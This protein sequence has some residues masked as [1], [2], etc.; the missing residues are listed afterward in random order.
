MKP[1]EHK[2]VLTR[3]LA[4]A[5]EVGWTFVSCDEAEQRRGISRDQWS[6]ARK[7]VYSS[8]MRW[9]QKSVNSTRSIPMWKVPYL[10]PSNISTPTS[11][12]TGT[13]FTETTGF[14]FVNEKFPLPFS[15]S[16]VCSYS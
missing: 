6:E 5:Q 12:A 1:R 3:I 10:D 9:M 11:K 13:S 2:T 14:I 15:G 16:P 4:Y 7:G 8:M